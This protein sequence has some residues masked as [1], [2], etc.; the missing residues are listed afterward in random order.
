M[1]NKKEE[2][3]SPLLDAI[4]Q[5]RSEQGI[6]KTTMPESS[7]VVDIIT[8]CDSSDYLNLPG[9][10]FNLFLSQR[11]ILKTFYMGTTG[12]ENL[13]LNKE[14]LQW[15]KLCRRFYVYLYIS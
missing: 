6:N 5:V 8:F 7:S 14:E 4:E 3:K 2:I 13:K 10:N 15:L 12:N 9:N 11:T 1:N